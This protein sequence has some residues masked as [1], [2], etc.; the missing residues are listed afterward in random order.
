MKRNR[1]H[2]IFGVN[3][4]VV[5]LSIENNEEKRNSITVGDALSTVFHQMRIAG[6]RSRTIESYQYI[7]EQFTNV[8]KL[9]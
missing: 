2:G 1:K 3:T 5:A 6:N 9:K 7:F 8:N 4:N